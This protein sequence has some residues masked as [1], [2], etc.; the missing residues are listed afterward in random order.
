[1]KNQGFQ[2]KCRKLDKYKPITKKD[3]KFKPEIPRRGAGQIRNMYS[4]ANDMF[5]N[6]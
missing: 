1:M 6:F 2:H 4:A 3:S 5:R